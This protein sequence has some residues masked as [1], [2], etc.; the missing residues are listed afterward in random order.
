[1]RGGLRGG[2][3]LWQLVKADFL[4]RVRRHSFLI[5]L[6]VT[7]FIGFVAVPGP[8]AN[9]SV[10]ALGDYRLVYNSAGVGLSVAVFTT[11]TLALAGFYL[12]SDALAR[13][14]RTG[15]GQIIA[16]TPVARWQYLLGKALSNYVTLLVLVAV[17]VVV[18]AIMQLAR[19]EET[20]LQ[21]GQL[22]APFL[23]ATV[24]ALAVVAAIAVV[25]ESIKAL[26]GGFGNVLYFFLWGAGLMLP[27]AIAAFV[28]RL[29]PFGLALCLIG[30]TAVLFDPFREE[31]ARPAR[32]AARSR[33]H[34]ADVAA[35]SATADAATAEIA[36]DEA[37]PGEWGEAAA[38]GARLT[39][40]TSYRFRLG[41]MVGAELRLMLYRRSLWWYIVAAAFVVVPVVAAGLNVRQWP[42]YAWLWP[43]LLW[44]GMGAREAQHGTEDIVFSGARSVRHQALAMW[45]AGVIVALGAGSG[46]GLRL[47]LE[48]DAAGVTSWLAGAL[49]I[50]SLALAC[51]V[52]SRGS[53]LFEAVYAGLWYVGPFSGYAGLDFIGAS[54]HSRAGMWLLVSGVLVAMAA[55]GRWRQVYRT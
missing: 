50:P 9:Y 32:P 26:R 41:P 33:K 43:L 16:A 35:V 4:D 2:V 7:A 14:R 8:D 44:S 55:I 48:A 28:A 24:P 31:E 27:I 23:Y 6:G 51:G 19:G 38:Y 54:G 12:V 29:W 40:L 45:L 18:A 39:S 30:L 36:A 13:D 34:H 21:A 22:L 53:K 3:A 42:A 15:V 11:L 20:A 49:F 47:L 37:E 46:V 1:M 5:T 52:L 10:F 17:M 25:F